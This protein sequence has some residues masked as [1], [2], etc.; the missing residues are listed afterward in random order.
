ML[1]H[2]SDLSLPDLGI[3]YYAG[4]SPALDASWEMISVAKKATLKILQDKL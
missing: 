3:A 1:P 2:G 4:S